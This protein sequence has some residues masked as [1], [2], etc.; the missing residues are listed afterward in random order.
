MSGS[1][2]GVYMY[3]EL[4][5]SQAEPEPSIDDIFPFWSDIRLV[6][7][8]VHPVRGYHPDVIEAQQN[9]VSTIPLVGEVVLLPLSQLPE[10]MKYRDMLLIGGPIAIP[11]A[12]PF[13]VIQ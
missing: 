1:G 5:K 7:G 8:K 11:S 10:G 3:N 6:P 4:A 2:V 13:M 9:I 12:G